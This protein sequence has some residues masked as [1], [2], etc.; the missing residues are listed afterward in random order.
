MVGPRDFSPSEL[1]RCGLGKVQRRLQPIGT[2]TRFYCLRC[3][4]QVAAERRD[5]DPDGWWACAR[6]CN[7]RFALVMGKPQQRPAP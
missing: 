7:T 2:W 4:T 3:G 6:G 1:E 5:V